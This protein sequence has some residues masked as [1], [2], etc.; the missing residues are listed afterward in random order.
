MKEQT[1]K[2]RAESL[3]ARFF[4]VCFLLVL[5][6]CTPQGP[7]GAGVGYVN[8]EIIATGWSGLMPK[9]GWP[10]ILTVRAGDDP[11]A[12]DM[13][14]D[15]EAQ[16]SKIVFRPRFPPKPD[17]RLRVSFT[18]RPGAEPMIA[19]F[20]GQAFP[21]VATTRV[22]QIYPTTDEWPANTL[23]MYVEFSFGMAKEEVYR[24]VRILD[25]QGKA[26]EGPFV[27]I[28]PELWDPVGRRVT[29]L[30]DPGRIKRGLVDNE[31]SGPP[32]VPGRTITIEV[33]AALRDVTGAPLVEMMRKTIRVADPLRKP[34]DVK[35]WRV[36]P[37]V[38]PSDALVVTFDR[39]LD[40]ALA[41]R[42]IVILKEGSRVKGEMALEKNESGLRFTPSE[43]WRPGA[44]TIRVDGVLEDIAGNRP[45]KLFDVDTTDR[46]QSTSATPVSELTFSI[47]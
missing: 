32:L 3:S 10:G 44:Y 5:A 36:A 15:Y 30:F 45:G 11:S 14:G 39:P 23:K 8:G 9:E 16:G 1:N 33:D 2:S 47:G 18:P 40:H 43:S 17:V 13:L 4:V 24:H 42:A 26:I 29:L 28:E 27:E 25:E 31:T 34:I 19:S 21:S 46:S 12:P 7:R 41:Q 35:L 37:P 6:A 20:G 38:A 22:A